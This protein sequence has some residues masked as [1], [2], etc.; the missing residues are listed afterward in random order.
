MDINAEIYAGGRVT[1]PIQF[2]KELGI[3]EGDTVTFRQE[4]GELKLITLEQQLERART[5]LKQHNAWDECS[6]EDFLKWRGEEAIREQEN[7]QSI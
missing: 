6:V 5:L 2:R 1:I 3:Q 7:D 4:G